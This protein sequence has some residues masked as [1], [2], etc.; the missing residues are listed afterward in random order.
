MKT[1]PVTKTR[2]PEKPETRLFDRIRAR[3]RN[4]G[5]SRTLLYAVLLETT[6]AALI[7]F[8]V[9]LSIEVLFPGI[10]L[11][12]LPVYPFLAVVLAL[13]IASTILGR[14]IRTTF[15]FI[16][17]RGSPFTWAGIVWIAFLLTMLSARIHP[18]LAPVIIFVFFALARM[19]FRRIRKNT[20]AK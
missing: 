9:F 8:A 3:A 2:I 5:W 18:M 4:V 17:H 1:R 16:P 19:F 7:I 13:I 12:Y 15:P 6:E 10:V 14:S 11:E 20:P